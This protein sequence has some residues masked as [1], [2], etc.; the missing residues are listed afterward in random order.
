M[1]ARIDKYFTDNYDELLEVARTAIDVSNRS[2]NEVDLVSHAY[3]YVIKK[4]HQIAADDIAKWVYQVILSHAR[5]RTSPINRKILLKQ[6]PFEGT[7][8]YIPVPEEVGLDDISDKV[9]LEKW[10]TNKKSLIELYRRKLE[11]QTNTKAKIQVLDKMIEFNTRNSRYLGKYFNV[12]YLSAYKY[13][14]EIQDELRAFEAE[15]NKYDN[16]NNINR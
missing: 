4:R 7:E 3:E 12:H 6:T 5:W 10:Y 11:Q 8:D 16:K 9:E 2:Y 1:K 15:L 14:K 13:I